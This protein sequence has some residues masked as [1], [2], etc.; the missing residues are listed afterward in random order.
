[1]G[2]AGL[3]F[4][5]TGAGMLLYYRRQAFALLSVVW[6]EADVFFAREENRVKSLFTGL[7][8]KIRR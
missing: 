5:G 8:R 2:V 6:T 7:V 3:L 1:M 4:L